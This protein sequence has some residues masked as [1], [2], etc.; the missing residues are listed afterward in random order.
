VNRIWIDYIK[1]RHE[2]VQLLK[3]CYNAIPTTSTH[4]IYTK[5]TSFMP[6][7][8]YFILLPRF[9][10]TTQ[11]LKWGPKLFIYKNFWA[12]F[13]PTFGAQPQ[14]LLHKWVSFSTQP[15]VLVL[16][17][18]PFFFGRV[19]LVAQPHRFGLQFSLQRG[20]PHEA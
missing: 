2:V 1:P 3:E 18:R 17:M 4:K 9:S 5:S 20:F 13:S 14:G 6:N 10:T 19:F 8:P 16:S 7:R 11:C 12:V 15:L